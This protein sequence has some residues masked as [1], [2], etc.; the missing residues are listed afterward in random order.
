MPDLGT[1]TAIKYAIDVIAYNYIANIRGEEIFVHP[2][3]LQP[4]WFNIYISLLV[5][6]LLRIPISK[7]EMIAVGDRQ[8][9]ILD[10]I[11]CLDLFIEPSKERDQDDYM[12]SLCFPQY[13]L[14]NLLEKQ[15]V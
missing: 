7:K 5:T 2:L 15:K 4:V 6:S 14:R 12:I 8:V 1:E 9:N 11:G 10:I 13:V 3:V